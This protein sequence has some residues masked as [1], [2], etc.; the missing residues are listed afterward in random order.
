MVEAKNRAKR[1]LIAYK[2]PEDYREAQKRE[3]I[4]AIGEGRNAIDFAKDEMGVK[5]ALSDAKAVIDQI[6]TNAQLMEEDEQARINISSCKTALYKTSYVYDGR[7]KEPVVTIKKGKIKLTKNEDY[8]VLYKN[9]VKVGTA[10]VT[11]SGT[12]KYKGKIT[13]T[14]KILP[15]G[16]LITGKIMARPRGF[17]VRW[18]KQKKYTSGYQIQYSLNKKFTK[19]TVTKTVK[20]NTDTKLNVK[21]L[22]PAKTYYVRIRT[23]QTVKGKRYCSAWSKVKNVVT[24]K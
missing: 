23:Y 3:L 7:K 5:K 16:T 11:I 2:N 24:K 9:N 21:K 15:E 12:G 1:E 10:Y 14:F 20:K 19:K 13:K 4:K 22:K 18:K 6:K 17:T 8:T